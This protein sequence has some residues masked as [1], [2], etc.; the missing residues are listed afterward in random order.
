[1][2]SIAL[3]TKDGLPQY[4]PAEEK[5]HVISHL[6]GVAMG[7]CMVLTALAKDVSRSERYSGIAFGISLIL[8]YAASCVY[9]GIRPQYVRLKRTF[10]IID[11]CSIFILIAGSSTPF[12]LCVLGKAEPQAG[13]FYNLLIW[14]IV[15]V[16]IVLLVIDLDR[17]RNVSIL[18]Y[19]VMGFSVT[20]KGGLL[21]A[22]I[23]EAGFAVVVAGGVAYC[24]GLILYSIK[25]RWTHA[26]FHVLCIVG[27]A[28]HCACVYAYIF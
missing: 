12:T 5:V 4:A 11:H 13:Q 1:L 17:F 15:A 19:L 26:A 22:G 24:I 7:I 16:G 3:S 14:A 9:H 28:L 10:R 25:I 8:L 18:L 21:K 2:S 6:F 23:G 20:L 27:S